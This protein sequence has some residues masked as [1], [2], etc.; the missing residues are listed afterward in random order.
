VGEDSLGFI[1]D[2]ELCLYRENVP[3][4]EEAKKVKRCNDNLLKYNDNYKDFI[5]FKWLVAMIEFLYY[6]FRAY[7]SAPVYSKNN[8]S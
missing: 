4:A 5:D 7:H 6:K 2:Y 3:G 8:L 1:D